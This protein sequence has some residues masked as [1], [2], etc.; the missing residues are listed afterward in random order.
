[1]L[2]GIPSLTWPSCS[3]VCKV[4]FFR[5]LPALCYL[6]PQLYSSLSESPELVSAAKLSFS[7]SR[8]AREKRMSSDGRSCSATWDPPACEPTLAGGQVARK[9]AVPVWSVDARGQW[10]CTS[11]CD[12][13]V[14]VAF[15]QIAAIMSDHSRMIHM[16]TAV[17]KRLQAAEVAEQQLRAIV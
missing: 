8:R 4:D 3:A 7:T 5:W 9:R 6:D 2:T 11:S 14:A 16:H 12:R 1:M 17:T 15:T 13:C 10:G